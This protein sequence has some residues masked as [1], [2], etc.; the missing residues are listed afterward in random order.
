RVVPIIVACALSLS[1]TL[2]GC[3]SGSSGG[4]SSVRGTAVPVPGTEVP[5]PST[6][7]DTSQSSGAN[8]PGTEASRFVGV[9]PATTDNPKYSISPAIEYDLGTVV[10]TR[11]DTGTEINDNGKPV[12]NQNGNPVEVDMGAN[13]I[14]VKGW[15]RYPV[16]AVSA[17]AA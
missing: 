12:K 10:V 9:A 2:N 14:P 16:A 3:G 8:A 1:L 7:T 13:A 4:S 11:S 6:P 15:M 5:P 17:N